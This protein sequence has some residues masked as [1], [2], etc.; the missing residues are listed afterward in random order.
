MVIL[1]DACIIAAS[2]N[3]PIVTMPDGNEAIETDTNEKQIDP[4]DAK[5]DKNWDAW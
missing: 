3:A 1:E 5:A 2:N 4:F